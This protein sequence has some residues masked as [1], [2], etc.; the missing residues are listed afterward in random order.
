MSL[1]DLLFIA[2]VLASV[3]ILSSAAILALIGR[4]ARAMATLRGYAIGAA[5]Y[6]GVVILVSL[7]APRRVLSVG[8]PLRFDDWC[9]AVEG[10]ERTDRKSVV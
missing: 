4:R 5:V 8:E 2:L 1:F 9:I 6:L 3:V 10:A 7:V